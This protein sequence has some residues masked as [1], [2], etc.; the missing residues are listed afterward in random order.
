MPSCG[1]IIDKLI[2]RAFNATSLSTM[3]FD[4]LHYFTSYFIKDKLIDL[5]ERT[6]N[7]KG[8]SYLAC[9][10]RKH[11]IFLLLKNLKRYSWA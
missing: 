11:I 6:F 1:E 7:R 3:I 8:S 5:I 2:A 10:D 9:N 4:P